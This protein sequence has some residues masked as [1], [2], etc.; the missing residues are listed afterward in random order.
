MKLRNVSGEARMVPEL[1]WRLVEPD[2]VIDVTDDRAPAYTC[3]T[4][5]WAAETTEEN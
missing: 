3:Q 4:A 1:G 2:E 5:T